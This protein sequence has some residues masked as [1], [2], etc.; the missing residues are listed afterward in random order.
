MVSEKWRPVSLVV[1]VFFF[2][3]SRRRHTRYIG[4]WS[5]DVCS[6]DLVADLA[7]GRVEQLTDGAHY[8]HSIDWSPSGEE[9]AFISNREPNE[10]QFFNYDLFTLRSEER[11][12]GKECRSRWDA[13]D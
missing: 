7:S 9:I 3:S 10:D 2:F 13:C 1:C 11:R 8:E 6:S 5:S 12:V 4:D